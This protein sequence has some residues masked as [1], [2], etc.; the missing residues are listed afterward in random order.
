MEQVKQPATD[1]YRCGCLE[2]TIRL[3]S[4]ALVGELTQ[5]LEELGGI[6]TP[7]GKTTSAGWTTQFSQGLDHQQSRV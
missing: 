1:Q 6:E 2:P 3:S 7:I 4:W 5:G